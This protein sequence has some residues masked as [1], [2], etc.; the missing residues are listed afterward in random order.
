MIGWLAAVVR[1]RRG[2]LVPV[3][4][5]LLAAVA[6]VRFNMRGP[7]GVQG[8]VTWMLCRSGS[9]WVGCLGA[10]PGHGS[11]ACQPDL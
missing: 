11:G 8:L 2:L 1:R 10:S 6:I 5:S 7:Q 4:M 9:Y 3:A